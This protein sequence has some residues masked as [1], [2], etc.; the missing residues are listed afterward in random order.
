M[1]STIRN[2]TYL[3]VAALALSG[4]LVRGGETLRQSDLDNAI[5]ATLQQEDSARG[6]ITSLLQRNEVR[7]L[8][9]GYGLDLRR[10]EAAVGT[11]QG[12]ELRSVSQLAANA[13]RQL[14][15]GDT[16]ISISLVAVL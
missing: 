10:A 9:S 15:G 3:L 4:S 7:A 2:V 16:T 1:N 11:L 8:A 5:A 12:D 6:A 13:D 14:T